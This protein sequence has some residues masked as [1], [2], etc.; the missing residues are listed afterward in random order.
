MIRPLL[1]FLDDDDDGSLA[2]ASCDITSSHSAGGSLDRSTPART[3]IDSGRPRVI[4]K[5]F[6]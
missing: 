1:P 5:I 2:V 3:T 6:W 4:W